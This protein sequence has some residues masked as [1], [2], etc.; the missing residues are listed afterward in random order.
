MKI[1]YLTFGKK[2]QKLIFFHGWQQGQN[3]FTPIVPYLHQNYRLFLLDLPGFG[4]TKLNNPQISF[5]QYCDQV[6]RWL[7]KTKLLPA[8]FIGHSFGGRMAAQITVDHPKKVKKLILIASGGIPEPKWWYPVIGRIPKKLTK[9]LKKFRFLLASRDYQAAGPLLPFFKKVVKQDLRPGFK[10]IKSP[11]LIIWGEQDQELPLNH[12]QQI[13]R[14][15][16]KSKLMILPGDHF[17]AQTNPQKTAKII[18][19]FVDAKKN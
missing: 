13:H 7:A 14:L 15:V 10:K 6:Y 3:S 9:P 17:V 11:T 16:P 12:G 8:V 5:E 18:K 4:Q 2:G 1:N 19:E